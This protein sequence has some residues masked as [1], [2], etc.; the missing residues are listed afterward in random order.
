MR[1]SYNNSLYLEYLIKAAK[2]GDP[3]AQDS[4][5]GEYAF[6]EILEKNDEKFFYWTEKSALSG[7]IN[8]QV[9]L[10]MAYYSGSN[11][12]KKDK[13]KAKKWFSLAADKGDEI[14]IMYF[15]KIR[16]E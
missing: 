4:L 15:N 3:I 11:G 8:A 7:Y 12:L 2:A 5:A 14:A 6:G 10:G 13:D 1:K 16:S 9:N